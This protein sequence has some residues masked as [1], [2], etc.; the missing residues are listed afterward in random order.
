[1]QNTMDK[2]TEHMTFR[3]PS[4]LKMRVEAFAPA[5]DVSPSKYIC[6]AVEERVARDVALALKLSQALGGNQGLPGG[7]VRGCDK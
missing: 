2:C 1:M 5:H 7:Q 6:E 4:E 3:C